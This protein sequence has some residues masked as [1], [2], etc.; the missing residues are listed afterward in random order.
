MIQ[1]IQGR[2]YQDRLILPEEML[3]TVP[4]DTAVPA[5]EDRC[6]KNGTEISSI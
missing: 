1:H 6:R 3:Q 2:P 4:L 5:E